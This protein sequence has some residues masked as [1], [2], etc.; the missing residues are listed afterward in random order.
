VGAPRKGLAALEMALGRNKDIRKHV[1]NIDSCRRGLDFYF[2]TLSQAQAFSQ[3]LSKLAPM[4]IK[5]TQKLVSTDSKNNT[6]HV[7][8]T[9][10]CDMVPLTRD[11]LVLVHKQSRGL[12]AGRLGLVTK[13]SSVI[14]IVDASPKR[15]L[16]MDA[17]ELSPEAYYKAGAD[18]GYPILQ[19]AERMIR[20]FVLDVELCDVNDSKEIYHGPASGIEKY[21]MADVQVARESDFGT[22]DLTYNCVT[23]LGHLIQPG[24][25]V[26]GYD[27]VSTSATLSTSSSLGVVDLEEVLHSN[28]VLPDV[29]LVKKVSAKDL[30]RAAGEEDTILEGQ[31]RVSK[32]KLRRQEKRDKKKRELGES[33]MRMGFFD[34]EEDQNNFSATLKND[35]ELQAELDAVERELATYQEAT[36]NQL[37]DEP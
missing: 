29:V 6:A 13:V 35:P 31:K 2:L 23:H 9:L 28:V 4:K 10:T 15:T 30:Q 18:K 5:T 21:A 7:K 27:L 25:V 36:T 19:T 22:N 33:A 34:D 20:F 24:D 12:L 26:L 16:T 3:F 32:K 8:H 11:D 17:M 37:M 1:L 14:H